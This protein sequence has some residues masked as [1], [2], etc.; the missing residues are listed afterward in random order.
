MPTEKRVQNLYKIHC[1]PTLPESSHN[2]DE[3]LKRK[4]KKRFPFLSISRKNFMKVCSQQ[5]QEDQKQY[6]QLWRRL[7]LSVDWSQTYETISPHSQIIS[8]RSF[9]DLYQKGFV[10]NRYTPI[11]WDTQFKTAVAQADIEDRPVSGFFYDIPFQ[12]NNRPSRENG[13]PN[14]SFVI[15]TTRPELLPACIA[16]AA[17]PEDERYKKFFS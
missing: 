2:L 16:V 4:G 7:A 11:F 8:Q 1:D 10:E 13:N 5:T 9:L 17:H 6:E 15:S 12:V 3:L 14:D